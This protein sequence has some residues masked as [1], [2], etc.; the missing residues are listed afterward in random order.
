MELN[1]SGWRVLV[2]AGFGETTPFATAISMG[3]DPQNRFITTYFRRPFTYS[4]PGADNT[5]VSQV[6]CA[7]PRMC[8]SACVVA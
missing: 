2:R 8:G 1:R 5:Y 6:R 4:K 3:A 7:W